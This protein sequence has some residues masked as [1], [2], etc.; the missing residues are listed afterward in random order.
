MGLLDGEVEAGRGPA[1]G[2][3]WLEPEVKGKRQGRTES[4]GPRHRDTWTRLRISDL[5]VLRKM[6]SLLEGYKQ[7]RVFILRISPWI[8]G[9]SVSE[10]VPCSYSGSSAHPVGPPQYLHRWSPIEGPERT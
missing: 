5:I 6:G 3:R 8:R 7:E 2:A 1:V 9:G 10:A 4:Q